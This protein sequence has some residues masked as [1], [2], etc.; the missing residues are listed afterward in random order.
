ME[1]VEARLKAL[2]DLNKPSVE[3]LLVNLS[4]HDGNAKENLTLK[5]T[6]K[7]FKLLRGTFNSFSL[8]NVAEQSGS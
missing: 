4:E 3:V 5:M 1:T 7:Y 2:E 8:S 6:F